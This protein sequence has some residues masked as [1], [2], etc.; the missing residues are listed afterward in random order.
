MGE[1]GY[2]TAQRA[3]V[4]IEYYCLAPKA[5]RSRIG[6]RCPPAPRRR[7]RP[8]CGSRSGG[9]TVLKFG[10]RVGSIVPTT[11][12]SLPPSCDLGLPDDDDAAPPP[13]RPKSSERHTRAPRPTDESGNSTQR[14]TDAA[15]SHTSMA[16]RYGRLQTIGEQDVGSAQCARERG[17]CVPGV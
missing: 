2:D 13:A 8:A 10:F 16:T 6:D 11:P 1:G 5:G 17:G 15:T 7:R 4:T 12:P 9:A 3:S 14:G